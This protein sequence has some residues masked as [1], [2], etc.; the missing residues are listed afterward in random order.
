VK[1]YAAVI[2]AD[3]RAYRAYHDWDV[4][5]LSTAGDVRLPVGYA[6]ESPIPVEEYLA[7]HPQQ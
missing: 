6:A 1:D 7:T 5:Y 3:P 4:I 2:A